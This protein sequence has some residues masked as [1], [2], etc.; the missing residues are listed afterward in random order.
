L[1]FDLDRLLRSLKPEKRTAVPAA[2]H[3]G[4][5]RADSLAAPKKTLI[6][7]TTVYIHAGQGKLPPKIAEMISQ[8][9]LLHSMTALG[10]IAYAIGHL[11]PAHPGT[12]ASRSYLESVLHR[13]PQHRLVSTTPEITIAGGVLTGIIARILSLPKGAHRQRINDVLIYLIARAN[14]AAVVTANVSDF[15]LL[16]QLLPD[17]HVIFY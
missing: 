13:I 14:G 11:D 6:P 5:L 10:E 2:R 4:Q 15:D 8:W 12:K 17:G 3:H 1:S 16:Q 7:D 9:P